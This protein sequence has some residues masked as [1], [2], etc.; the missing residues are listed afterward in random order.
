MRIACIRPAV[1]LK[2]R[3]GRREDLDDK[4]H[5]GDSLDHRT[6]IRLGYAVCRCH[7]VNTSI[8]IVIDANYRDTL[9]SL[10][11]LSSIHLIRSNY[12]FRDISCSNI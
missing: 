8:T 1:A 4:P 2:F 9:N 11:N 10:R 7:R 3:G 5:I 12:S 6:A